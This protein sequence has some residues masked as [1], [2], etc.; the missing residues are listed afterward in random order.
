MDDYLRLLDVNEVYAIEDV[1][2]T[3]RIWNTSSKANTIDGFS[4]VRR[5]LVRT[6]PTAQVATWE[7]R[8]L[9]QLLGQLAKKEKPEKKLAELRGE[10]NVLSEDQRV[11][12]GYAVH[13]SS[14]VETRPSC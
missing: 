8:Y 2:A 12:R 5:Y 11:K 9:A 13:F 14:A 1:S 4:A 3:S 10:I 7:G 6:V